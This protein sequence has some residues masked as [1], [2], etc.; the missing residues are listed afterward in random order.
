MYDWTHLMN[1]YKKYVKKTD[2]VLEIGA[3]TVERT[4]ELSRYCKKLIGLEYF[5]DRTPKDF[6][7]VKYIIGDWQNLS[8]VI[9]K[10]SVDLV[11]SSHVIEHIPNDLEAINETYEVLKPGGVALLNT[12]NR[13]RLTRAIIELFTGPRKFPYWEHQREYIKKDLINLINMSKFKKFNIIPILF[14]INTKYIKIYLKKFPDKL[15]RY[16][17]YWEIHLFK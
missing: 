6:D 1:S 7:N 14:G 13:K 11:V 5:P 8:K 10:G 12:P 2:T 4:K 15:K 17:N 3:S 9:K 16:V